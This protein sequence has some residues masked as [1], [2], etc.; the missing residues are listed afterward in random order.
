MDLMC[1]ASGEQVVRADHKD[2]R[3]SSAVYTAHCTLHTAHRT[4]HTKQ[5]PGPTTQNLD[6]I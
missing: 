2:S 4:L 3:A 5:L 1:L 6:V